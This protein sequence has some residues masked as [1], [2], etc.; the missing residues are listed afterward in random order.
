MR[1]EGR[2]RARQTQGIQQQRL[3]GGKEDAEEGKGRAK[4]TETKS[5][6]IPPLQSAELNIKYSA[7]ERE[8]TC[9]TTSH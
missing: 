5:A 6:D 4:R 9:E 8:M 1:E 7:C 2:E 3:N